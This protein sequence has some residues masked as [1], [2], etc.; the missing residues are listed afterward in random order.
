ITPAPGKTRARINLRGRKAL[1]C[2]PIGYN[3]VLLRPPSRG[4]EVAMFDWLKNMFTRRRVKVVPAW[5]TPPEIRK[6]LRCASAGIDP[7]TVREPQDGEAA[8]APE[9]PD[10]KPQP[11]GLR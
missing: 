6:K 8:S 5:E 1:L 10:L 4:S 3:V 2:T 11:P 7:D 9:R